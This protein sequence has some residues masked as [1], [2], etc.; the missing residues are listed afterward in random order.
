MKRTSATFYESMARALVLLA[1]G[2]EEIEAVTIVDVL[3]R[4]GI[5]V[6]LASL[7]EGPVCGSHDIAVNPDTSLERVDAGEYDALVLPGGMPGAKYL[8]SDARVLDLV[9]AFVAQRKLTAAICAGPTVLLAAGV[10]SGVRATGYPGFA[11][12][13][14]LYSEDRVVED[15]PILTSR[16]PGTAMD[17]AL[18]L[19]KRLVGPEIAEQHRTRLLAG[20]PGQPA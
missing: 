7:E 20:A 3:R 2:F 11:L 4:A 19:V 12:P 10:L 1:N 15:G 16:G 18:A 5:Q 17:F 9:R 6:T 13:G 14:S 8:A